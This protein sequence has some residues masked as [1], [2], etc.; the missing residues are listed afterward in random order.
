MEGVMNKLNRSTG[1]KKN[2]AVWA[3]GVGE[4]VAAARYGGRMVNP[5]ETSCNSNWPMP[6]VLSKVRQALG[7]GHADLLASGRRGD[8]R[9]MFR[10]GSGPSV[11]RSWEDFG[12]TGVDRVIC[13]TESGVESAGT[14][15]KPVPGIEFKIADDGEILCR[16][17]NVFKGYFKDDASTASTLE[18]GW[19]HTGDLA[20]LSKEGLVKIRGRKKEILKTSGGKMVAPLP[21]EEEIKASPIISQVCMVGDGRKY[22]A[23][24][25]TLSEPTL[26]ELQAPRRARGKRFGGHATGRS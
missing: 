9:R 20:E 26:I 2:L 10:A 1:T 17:R 5:L 12:Q 21:I 18:G 6:W 3:L 23:A 11:S 7:L 25:I 22:L 15:G 14:V 8:C 24:L 13:M 4:R 16:G 19:L